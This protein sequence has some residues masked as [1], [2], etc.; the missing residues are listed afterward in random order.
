ML[1]LSSS[2]ASPGPHSALIIASSLICSEARRTSRLSR[3]SDDKKATRIMSV[4]RRNHLA[5]H[6]LICRTTS[7]LKMA[8][9]KQTQSWRPSF[10]TANQTKST[11]SSP[12]SEIWTHPRFYDN[13]VLKY[14]AWQNLSSIQASAWARRVVSH[15]PDSPIQY[16]QVKQHPLP[17]TYCSPTW[18]S[19]NVANQLST[20]I[21]VVKATWGCCGVRVSNV[22]AVCCS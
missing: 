21:N 22:D 9:L 6:V 19:R 4:Q 20:P 14:G 12:Q 1:Y 2:A 10:R 3:L 13:K 5:L 8:C 15:C 17:S 16:L 11:S 18:Y 7:R